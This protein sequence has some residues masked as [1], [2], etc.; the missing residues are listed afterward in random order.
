MKGI[1]EF[2]LPMEDEQFNLHCKAMDYAI[3]I[4][5]ID[6]YLR[7]QLK[8]TERPETELKVLQ[9]IRDKLWELRSSRDI[10]P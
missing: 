4:D 2:E 5:E 8:Y 1:L 6:E 3:C 9:E 7:A 10:S